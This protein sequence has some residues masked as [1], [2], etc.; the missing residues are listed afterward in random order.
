MFGINDMGKFCYLEQLCSIHFRFVLTQCMR[1]FYR[2]QIL[3]NFA[4]S[5]EFANGF[6][7]KFNASVSHLNFNS[8]F[9]LDPI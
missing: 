4:I 1:K 6:C 2:S 3:R 5:F 9:S 8:D 7:K